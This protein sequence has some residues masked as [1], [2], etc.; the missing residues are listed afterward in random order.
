MRK[1]ES[2][3]GPSGH[4][5]IVFRDCLYAWRISLRDG[6]WFLR[7]AGEAG[8]KQSQDAQRQFGFAKSWE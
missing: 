3:P 5:Q 8:K 4:E 2:D 7:Q 6:R 1:H